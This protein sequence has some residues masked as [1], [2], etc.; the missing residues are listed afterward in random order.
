ETQQKKSWPPQRP[1]G[2]DWRMLIWMAVI[3]MVG[4]YLS[5]SMTDSKSVQQ[6]S[7]TQ[8]RQAVQAGRVASVTLHGQDISG[9]F[10]SAAPEQKQAQ[11]NR[12]TQ[13]EGQ[14][15]GQGEGAA[16]E[17]Q[18]SRF[19]TTRP[20]LE[21]LDLMALLQEHNVDVTAKPTGAPWWQG[22]LIG[23]LPWVIMIAIFIFIVRRMRQRMGG[24]SGQGGIF[25]FGRSRARRHREGSTGVT[26]QQV[27]GASNAK[28]DLQ[29]IIAYLREPNRY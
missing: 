22:L 27:A 6:L 24:G 11:K 10:K 15:Q 2:F 21:G 26:M 16:G 8:F 23:L 28:R 4:A 17:S 3:F 12:Q 29:E 7:Y 19:S 1:R 18:P 5:S 25:G 14:G 9:Q 20:D 13:A